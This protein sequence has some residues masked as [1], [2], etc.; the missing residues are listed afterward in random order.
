[1]FRHCVLAL[2]KRW[3]GSRPLCLIFGLSFLIVSARGGHAQ[4]ARR[5]ALELDSG[6]SPE[7]QA[8]L[9]RTLERHAPVVNALAQSVKAVAGLTRPTVV[10]IEADVDSKASRTYGRRQHVEEAGSGVIVRLGDK[11]Y[12]LTNRHVIRNSSPKRIRI[13]LADKRQIHPTKIWQHP[14]TDVAVMAVSA[15]GLVAAKVGDSDQIEVGDFVVAMGSPFGLDRS[16]TYGVVSAKSRH[17]LQLGDADVKLQDFIQTDAAINPGNSGGPLIN[18]RG[19]IVG[20]NTAIASNSGHNEG[21][22]FAIP[23]NMVMFFGRQLVE[24]GKVTRAYLGVTLQKDF[25]PAGAVKIGLPY[26][27]GAR[28]SGVAEGTPAAAAKLQVGDVI[29]WFNGLRVKDDAHLVN[30]VSLTDVGAAVTLV[31]FRDGKQV[32]VQLEV[33]T[34]PEKPSGGR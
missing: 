13:T 14:E 11:H 16:L 29:L 4:D 19:E 23:I 5:A 15:P 27:T 30:L 8:E 28:I 3:T 12:V 10:H 24:R 7:K 1:M 32:D 17:D 34:L 9:Y 2:R 18:L 6:L 20:I 26:P 25:G 33:G 22:G 31:V 21:I